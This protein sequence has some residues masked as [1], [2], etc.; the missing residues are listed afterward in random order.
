MTA[1][2]PLTQFQQRTGFDLQGEWK[3]EINRM[4]DLGYATLDAKRFQLTRQGLRYA[5]W[6][7]SEF[8]RS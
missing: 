3:S 1:G 8:L 6:A 7:A 5:D 2:W 4:L